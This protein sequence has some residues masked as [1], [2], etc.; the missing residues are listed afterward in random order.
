M[1]VALLIFRYGPSHGSILQTYALTRILERLGHEVT[2]IDRQP[3]VD[4]HGFITCVKRVVKG[5][6]N[7]N[8]SSLDFYLG[9]YAPALM[10]NINGFIDKELRYQTITLNTENGLQKIGEGDYD[11]FIVGSDQ[12][13]RP[14]YVYNVYNYFLNFVSQGRKVKRIAYAPSF[15]TSDWEYTDKQ[16]KK[17]KSLI[18]LFD[19]VSVREIDG[20]KM[21]KDHFDVEATHVLDPTMLLNVSDYQQ[22]IN[23]NTDNNY[24]GYNFLNPTKKKIELSKQ[25]SK[26]LKLPIKRLIAMDDRQLKVKER[27]APSIEDWL[28]GIAKSRF[29]IVDSFHATVFSIIFHIDFIAIGNESRGLSRFTSLLNAL[30]LQ[31]R[32]VL[33]DCNI[34][35]EQILKPIDWKGVDYRW[36]QLKSK[37]LRF[38]TEHLK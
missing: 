21:C 9:D 20:V 36:N 19:C 14:K 23:T 37:S 16:E 12:T 11:A 29:V 3:S 15:G 26:A 1:K 2:I 7:R 6:L 27:I 25:V 38:L 33:A 13:W 17:C 10:R 5:V 8:V 32:L 22:F 18:H 24:V 34:N 28:T 31:D 30:G 35:E 4:A